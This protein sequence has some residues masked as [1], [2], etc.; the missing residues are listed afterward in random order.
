MLYYLQEGPVSI[1]VYKLITRTTSSLE[2]YNGVLGRLIQSHG[3]FFRFVTSI[4]QQELCKSRELNL[5]IQ[6]GGLSAEGKKKRV[7][8]RHDKIVEA[9][10]LFVN[11]SLSLPDYLK[12]LTFSKNKIVVNMA[13]FSNINTPCA[14]EDD[15]DDEDENANSESIQQTQKEN[16]LT[17]VICMFNR[18]DTLFMP[19]SHLNACMECFEILEKQA[20]ERN[21]KPTCPLCRKDINS[22]MK[23]LV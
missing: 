8:D 14:E 10:E 19:C 21:K 5:L 16:A 7:K 23:V 2:A 18:V 3:D 9:T 22:T 13:N 6:S 17:C 12:R 15:E 11:E 20:I 1:S 4:Q